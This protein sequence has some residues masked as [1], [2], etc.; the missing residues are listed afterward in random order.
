MTKRSTDPERLTDTS[1]T[2]LRGNAA[3]KENYR[4][5]SL[6]LNVLVTRTNRGYYRG[7]VGFTVT[8]G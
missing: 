3:A 5:S 1:D 4:N 8:C 7:S 2:V 6:R